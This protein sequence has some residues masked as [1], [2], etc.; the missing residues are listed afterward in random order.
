MLLSGL[1]LAATSAMAQTQAPG[2]GDCPPPMPSQGPGQQMGFP[3]GGGPPGHRGPGGP[4]W[5][6]QGGF[7][8]PDGTTSTMRGGLQ[9]GPPGRWWDDPEFAKDLGLRPEQKTRMDD[10]FN[11]NRAEIFGSFTTLLNEES[12][13]EKIT[14]ENHPDEAGDRKSVV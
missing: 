14:Q 13:L 12:T 1:L 6:P 9:L 11:A 10:I 8:K 7:S 4:P 3:D 2:T 5:G